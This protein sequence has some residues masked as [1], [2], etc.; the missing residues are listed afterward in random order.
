MNTCP[1]CREQN[2][3]TAKFCQGCGTKLATGDTFETR[4]LA[5]IV[6]CDVTGSTALGEK[7]DP[8]VL[9]RLITQYFEEMRVVLTRHGGTV[10]KFIGDA[11]MA[12]FGV[13][14]VHEDDAVRAVRA[15][16]EMR[17]LVAGIVTPGTDEPGALQVRI[18]VNTGDVIAGDASAGHGFVSGDAVNVAARLEQAAAPGQIL[19]GESTY[20]LAAAFVDADPVPALDLKGKSEAVPAYELV[21]VRSEAGRTESK[22][23]EVIGRT[24]ELSALLAA[25]E[26]VVQNKKPKWVTV[27]GPAGSGKSALIN[28][29]RSSV[30]ER[31]RFLSGHC[32]SY[33]EGITFWPIAEMVKQAAGITELDGSS[34]EVQERLRALVEDSVDAELLVSRL[35]AALGLADHVSGTQEIMWAIRTLLQRLASTQPVVAFIEDVH[36]AEPT[37]L[38]LVEYLAAFVQDSPVLI[39]TAG[40]SELLEQR[41]QW[42]GESVLIALEPLAPDDVKTL[43]RRLVGDDELPARIERYVIDASQGNPLYIQEILK[44]LLEEKLLAR[45]DGRWRAETQLEDYRVPRTI[46]ALL[47]ARLERLP[48]E[49]RAVVQHG[50]VVGKEF[51]FGAVNALTTEDL[52]KEVGRSLHSLVRRDLLEPQLSEFAGEDSFRFAQSLMR[53]AAYNALPKEHRAELHEKVAAWLR[54]RAGD[55]VDEYEEILGYHLEQAALLR[56]AIGIADDATDRLS[57]EAGEILART[58]R[59]ALARGDLQASVGLLRRAL[60][61]VGA[62][63]YPGLG[64]S[65]DLS[66]ALM[67]AGELKEASEAVTLAIAHG[68]ERQDHKM[69]ARA[70]LQE[71][72]LQAMTDHDAWMESAH[73]TVQSLLVEMTKLGDQLGQTRALLQ[74]ADYHWDGLRTEKAQ[75]L[76]HQAL[77]LAQAVGDRVEEGRIQSYL[78]GAAFWGP[79]PVDEAI[80]LCRDILDRGSDDQIVM[81]TTMRMLGGLYAMRGDFDE[82]RESHDA[83]RILAHDLGQRLVL[84]YT[85]QISGVIELLAGDA[86]AAVALFR[87]GFDALEAMGEQ[88]YLSTQAAF[89]AR[90]LLTTGRI[91][92]AHQMT[93]VSERAADD[94]TPGLGI[95]EWG[96]TR[97]RVMGIRGELRE[98]V[99]LAEQVIGAIQQVEDVISIGDGYTAVAE[100]FEK[101]GQ[102]DRARSFYEDALAAYQA[103]GVRPLEADVRARL[104]ALADAAPELAVG[105]PV[106]PAPLGE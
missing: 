58:G 44:M 60:T 77:P 23:A 68:T 63:S 41:P 54:E 9:R 26:D 100:L 88:A 32:L 14:V 48:Q 80:T 67:E 69:V 7:L 46:Q 102:H 20:R 72:A 31:A 71:I 87:E 13:P 18:G 76:L 95:A 1:N 52:R 51:W 4:K 2:A 74:L 70:R 82:G 38:D 42:L 30:S 93:V 57:S 79:M 43:L 73:D 53:D 101:A 92:E 64:L 97:V 84:A 61:L 49:E 45:S 17:A 35:S 39:V 40:R 11:V 12:V 5:S 91:D 24:Q 66:R 6:F 83:G 37:L 16:F 3:P 55:R 10:E 86:E 47:A 90:A 19:I 59:R 106:Q 27:T 56:R 36:W 96:P 25:F 62:N 85:T 15:A 50:S 89:L 34:S 29:F 21:G 103:K 28:S 33:G 75:E 104:N 81:A 94:T 65:I 105:P 22:G 98:A 8:E 99:R 78:A